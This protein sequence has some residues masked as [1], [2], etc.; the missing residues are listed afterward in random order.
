M[1]SFSLLLSYDKFL[2]HCRQYFLYGALIS[3]SFTPWL[4]TNKSETEKVV[5]LFQTDM[6]DQ[7]YRKFALVVGG[8]AANG[9]VLSNMIHASKQGYMELLY[10]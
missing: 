2:Q 4:L 5:R 8:D 1:S 6:F 9:R 10:D 7:E 3:A